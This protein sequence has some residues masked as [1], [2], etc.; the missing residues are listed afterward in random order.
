MSGQHIGKVLVI[1][2]SLEQVKPLSDALARVGLAC[3]VVA[4][5]S[6][7]SFKALLADKEKKMILA[8]NTEAASISLDE[9]LFHQKKSSPSSPF[10]IINTEYSPDQVVYWMKTGVRDVITD[11]QHEHMALV[12][13]REA[14]RSGLSQ[15]Q[16]PS[17][18]AES[19]P[20][21]RTEIVT[22]GQ[23]EELASKVLTQ[24]HKS[25][26]SSPQDRENQT[27]FIVE[28]MDWMALGHKY[29]KEK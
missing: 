1:N 11:G 18:V 21:D 14:G 20:D 23:S 25:L 27:L 2:K 8:W 6:L 17:E 29:G 28:I 5:E 24:V 12:L 19:R 3:D 15:R 9:A 22:E 7:D 26:I 4:I 10:L 16:S 13:A